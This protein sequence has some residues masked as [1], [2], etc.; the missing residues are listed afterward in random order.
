MDKKSTAKKVALAL[1][2]YLTAII[3]IAIFFT[4]G[5]LLKDFF[6]KNTAYICFGISFG[7]L[8]LI[9][10]VQLFLASRIKRN[11]AQNNVAL[12]NEKLLE[13]QN[14][15]KSDFF[16]AMKRVNSATLVCKLYVIAVTLLLHVIVFFTGAA[17]GLPFFVILIACLFI[18]NIYAH[19][20]SAL[21]DPPEMIVIGVL[22]QDEYGELYRLA[23]DAMKTAGVEGEL[24]ICTDNS[25]DCSITRYGNTLQILIGC[26][27][28]YFFTEKELYN[29]FLHEFAHQSREYTPKSDN[30]VFRR[31]IE[32]DG[33][34]VTDLLLAYP[35]DRYLMERMLFDYLGSVFVEQ[36]ADS[37]VTSK[38][39]R[40]AMASALA[41]SSLFE[42]FERVHQL[43][44]IGHKFKTPE[45][46]QNI[47]E[48]TAKEL[49]AAMD[50][51]LNVW[52]ERLEREIQPKNAT[53]PIYRE[54]R[55]AIGVS[56][57]EV[58]V[59]FDAFGDSLDGI[60]EKILGFVSKTTA[61]Y[62]KDEYLELRMEYYLEPLGRVQYWE[63]NKADV[64]PSQM[65]SVMSA[66]EYLERFDEAEALADQIIASD[67][68]KR[69]KAG[70]YFF[71]AKMLLLRDDE[72]GIEM[73][74]T[75]LD[76][77]NEYASLGLELLGT[78]ICRNGMQEKL[79]EYREKAP[80]YQQATIDSNET[81]GTLSPKDKLIPEEDAEA[82]K[83]HVDNI[84]NISDKVK[85]IWVCRKIV[86]NESARCFG[87]TL[88][89]Q[90]EDEER[91]AVVDIYMYIDSLDDGRNTMFLMNRYSFGIMKKV[92]GALVYSKDK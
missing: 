69:V 78:F 44:S 46:I 8:I 49:K 90:T 1:L 13:K 25:F 87:I 52:L 3:S 32:S 29:V 22:P 12:I 23:E 58:T 59:S 37:I 16:A 26:H 75:A 89:T 41:K 6:P 48:C 66:L 56:A 18:S 30:S 53:H 71:K 77:D 91:R 39:D 47:A 40:I 24:I 45:P 9:F 5:L 83:R 54:R 17:T 74:Y 34:T 31:F 72:A 64:S 79:D 88:D 28:I 62:M 42:D 36:M 11:F 4:A 2:P 86:G 7:L 60:R 84:L 80:V 19:L 57:D 70:A 82:V 81:F 67:L 76:A 10:I 27:F 14:E 35:T 85:E 65:I 33:R 51:K 68:G 63:E 15:I 92:E 50:D 43:Y 38:G 20:F 73:M 61:Q 55:N 21:L